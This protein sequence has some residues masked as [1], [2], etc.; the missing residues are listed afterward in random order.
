MSPSLATRT[1]ISVCYD[2]LKV[3]TAWLP[4]ERMSPA[5]QMRQAELHRDRVRAHLRG[6][7]TNRLNMNEWWEDAA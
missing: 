7:G 4:N 1:L 2:G 3:R 6:T 5:T